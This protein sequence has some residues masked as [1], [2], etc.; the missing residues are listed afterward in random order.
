MIFDHMFGTYAPE[1]REVANQYGLIEGIRSRN[2]FTIAFSEWIHMIRDVP[3]SKSTKEFLLFL[4]GPP[5]WQPKPPE[6]PA[7]DSKEDPINH[8]AC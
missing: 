8:K 3:K 7:D 2:P 5:Y 6:S 4:F 1:K